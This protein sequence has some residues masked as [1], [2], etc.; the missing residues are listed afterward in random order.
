MGSNATDAAKAAPLCMSALARKRTSRRTS[1]YV[2]LVPQAVVSRRSK[3]ARLLDHHVGGGEQDLRYLKVERPRCL[4]VD[5]QV[6][7]DR[8]FHRQICGL[9]TFQDAIDIRSRAPKDVGDVG[10]VRDQ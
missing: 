1:W 5:G 7:F 6:V 4:E 8:C 9:G 3:E 10:P 2:R